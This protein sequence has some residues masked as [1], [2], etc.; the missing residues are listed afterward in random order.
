[1]MNADDDSRAN[2]LPRRG[3]QV[4]VLKDCLFLA[5]YAVLGL[6]CSLGRV[7]CTGRSCRC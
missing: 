1:M 3:D 5:N 2:V 7:D 6:R 4:A